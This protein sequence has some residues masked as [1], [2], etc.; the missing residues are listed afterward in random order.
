[1]H[2]Q[3]VPVSLYLCVSL[4]RHA[5]QPTRPSTAQR[6][7]IGKQKLT[8]D[9]ED[10][11]SPTAC[12]TMVPACFKSLSKNSNSWALKKINGLKK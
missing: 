10:T 3:S 1:M 6:T 4:A 8:S 2:L 12:F 11:I 5:S 9:D 7:Q